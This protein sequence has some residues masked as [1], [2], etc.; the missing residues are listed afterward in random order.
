MENWGYHGGT[1][2]VFG[3]EF[4]LLRVQVEAMMIVSKR[5]GLLCLIDLC[6]V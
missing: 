4:A 3:R 5:I 6:K 1:W 2:G